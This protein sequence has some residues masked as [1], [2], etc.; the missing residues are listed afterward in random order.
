MRATSM[1]ST[2]P[3]RGMTFPEKMMMNRMKERSFLLLCHFS[4]EKEYFSLSIQ[5]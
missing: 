4:V 1:K 5:L 2:T 3:L